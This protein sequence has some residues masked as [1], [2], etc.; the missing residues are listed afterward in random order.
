MSDDEVGE[1]LAILE[2]CGAREHALG[3][4]RRYRDRALDQLEQ[5]PC[6]PEGKRELALLVRAVIAA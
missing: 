6:L 5:L 2:R 4:A 3:E 1:V